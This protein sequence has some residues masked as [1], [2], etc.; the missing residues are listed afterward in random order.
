MQYIKLLDDYPT[1][2]N[3]GEVL[4][5]IRFKGSRYE[6]YDRQSKKWIKDSSL[7][8]S[9]SCLGADANNYSSISE[10]EANAIIKKWN[11]QE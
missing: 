11:E 9:V 1:S 7:Y 6:Y 10:A 4:T 3:Y 8:L 5:L 2:K